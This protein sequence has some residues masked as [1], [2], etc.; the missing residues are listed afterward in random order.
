MITILNTSILTRDGSFNYVSITLNEGK[1][2]CYEGFESAIGQ[3]ST[4]QIISS[5]LGINCP[6]NRILYKQK[7]GRQPLVFKLKGRPTEGK[8]LSLLKIEKIVFAW[9]VLFNINFKGGN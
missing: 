2:F 4:A 3:Q 5:L 8:I 9:G 6:V 7:P 1:T